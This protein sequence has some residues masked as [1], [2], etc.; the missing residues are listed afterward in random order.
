M[1]ENRASDLERYYKPVLN[2]GH[3]KHN[4]AICRRIAHEITVS[5]VSV[6]SLLYVIYNAKLNFAYTV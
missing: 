3:L 4:C 6:L 1:I 5:S 2:F